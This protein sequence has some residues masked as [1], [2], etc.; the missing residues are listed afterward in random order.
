[1][2]MRFPYPKPGDPIKADDI[3][4]LSRN[5]EPLVNPEM[6]GGLASSLIGGSRRVRALQTSN[7]NIPVKHGDGS[8]VPPYGIVKVVYDSSLVGIVHIYIRVCTR[9]GR[10]NS[11][12]YIIAIF[13]S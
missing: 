6:G 1:M 2:E 12:I 13:C 7:Y 3:A 5:L 4:Y 8:D 9:G 11:I 10:C